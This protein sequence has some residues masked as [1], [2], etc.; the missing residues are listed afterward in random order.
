MNNLKER[1]LYTLVIFFMVM[2]LLLTIGRAKAEGPEIKIIIPQEIVGDEVKSYAYIQVASAFGQNHW[3]SFNN[4][5]ERESQWNPVNQ[6]PVSTAYGLGQFLNSTWQDTGIKKTS[7]PYKQIDA[8]IIYVMKRY[9]DPNLAWKF[10]RAH[11]WY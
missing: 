8:T 3:N 10:W 2:A 4:I 7:D 5:I 9:E 11:L 1:I 6:N